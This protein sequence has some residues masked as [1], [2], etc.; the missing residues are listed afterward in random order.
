MYRLLL[1]GLFLLAP[2]S[3]LASP[4][5]T[6]PASESCK[7][8]TQGILSALQDGSYDAA[9]ISNFDASMKAA[10]SAQMN[11]FW[12]LLSEHYGG[13]EH[14][15]KAQIRM[16]ASGQP[17]IIL[18]LTFK[19]GRENLHVTC[20]AAGEVIGLFLTPVRKPDRRQ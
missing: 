1:I 13:F 15:T 11:Q 14:S 4:P 19:H 17:S 7:S 2:V 12:A 18:P 16:T 3:V 8:G 20:N 5:Q 6:T 9:G 10:I